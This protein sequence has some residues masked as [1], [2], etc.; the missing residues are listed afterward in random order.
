[1]RMRFMLVG[2]STIWVIWRSE[3]KASGSLLSIFW[4][5][6][7]PIRSTVVVDACL[8]WVLVL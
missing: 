6:E 5:I 7:S 4:T 3:T 2:A 8:F 1:M